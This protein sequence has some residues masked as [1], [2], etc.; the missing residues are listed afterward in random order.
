MPYELR[1]EAPEEREALQKIRRQI[2]A[3][4][5]KLG[6]YPSYLQDDPRLYDE[7]GEDWADCDT[8]LLQL[9]DD[10]CDYPQEGIGDMELYLNGGPL[11]FVI[12]AQDLERR[13]FSRV[14]AQWACT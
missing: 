14:L 6:G 5:C 2:K 4:G 1:E 3:G 10:T 8:L 12:R 7:D 11:N 9:Y 13:D